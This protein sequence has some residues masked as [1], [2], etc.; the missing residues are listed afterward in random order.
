MPHGSHRKSYNLLKLRVNLTYAKWMHYREGVDKYIYI[1]VYILLYSL[2]NILLVY[3]YDTL[4]K[5][6]QDFSINSW[7]LLVFRLDLENL[8]TF[9][10]KVQILS[11]H[12][13]WN[14]DE[15]QVIQEEQLPRTVPQQVSEEN[16]DR[17]HHVRSW[18]NCAWLVSK[19]L[20]HIDSKTSRRNYLCKDPR[21]N[22]H[23][24][25][26]GRNGR[27]GSVR[28]IHLNQHASVEIRAGPVSCAACRHVN[29]YRN[30]YTREV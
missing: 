9:A 7:A 23:W 1:Y 18:C 25:L 15:D 17:V 24:R 30:F 2:Y 4:C 19:D 21:R 20:F 22:R 11:F 10:P 8:C 5:L 26:K 12:P 3:T 29:A 13:R 28:R 27:S 6:L 16:Q 14:I